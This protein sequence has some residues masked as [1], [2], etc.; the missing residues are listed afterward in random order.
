MSSGRSTLSSRRRYSRGGNRR[1]KMWMIAGVLPALYRFFNLYSKCN[2]KS[3]TL[4]VVS[5]E[6]V[7]G[8]IL[9]KYHTQI[10]YGF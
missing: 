6:L 2:N 9:K 5:F 1:G 7:W 4:I 3:Q 8:K 10:P